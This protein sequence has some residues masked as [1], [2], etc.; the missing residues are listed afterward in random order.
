MK[1]GRHEFQTKSPCDRIMWYVCN[2]GGFDHI[3]VVICF[4]L[5]SVL[6]SDL[7]FSPQRI[8]ILPV[9]WLF[10]VIEFLCT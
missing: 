4:I 2:R 9:R 10:Y 3:N 7:S 1:S 8:Y 5:D 6:R